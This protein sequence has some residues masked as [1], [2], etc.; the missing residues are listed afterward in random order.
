MQQIRPYKVLLFLV[1]VMSF[2]CIPSALIPEEGV[3][4]LGVQWR[5][6]PLERVWVAKKQVKKNIDKIVAAVDTTNIN[7]E[8][9]HIGNSAG[10]TGLPEGGLLASETAHPLQM[11][12]SAISK[13]HLFFYCASR[14]RRGPKNQYFSLRRLPN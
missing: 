5:F 13:L 6:L 14:G 7:N 9:K 3:K 1:L 8:I 10:Q 11:S 2:L 4:W 12:G